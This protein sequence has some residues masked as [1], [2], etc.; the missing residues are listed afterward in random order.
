MKKRGCLLFFLFVPVLLYAQTAVIQ[1]TVRDTEGVGI[2][3][4]SINVY[5]ADSNLFGFGSTDSNG[6]Y[7]V[8]YLYPAS[9]YLK[10]YSTQNYL[11][12]WY[13]GVRVG[14]CDNQGRPSGATTVGVWYDGQI[15]SSIDF[16]L[17]PGAVIKG[18]VTNNAGT[19]IQDVW[20][21][22]YYSEYCTWSMKTDSSGFYE[23][24]GL[25]TGTYHVWADAETEYTPYLSEWY[26]DYL[27]SDSYPIPAEAT[28]I[29]VA[30]GLTNVIDIGLAA[31]GSISGRV[32][33][34][35]TGQG[36][37]RYFIKVYDT[38]LVEAGYALADENGGYLIPGL[39]SGL[40]V[41]ATCSQGTNYVNERYDDIPVRASWWEIDGESLVQVQKGVCTSGIDF[42]L[43]TGAAIEGLIVD[44]DGYP[45]YDAGILYFYRGYG[46]V[47]SVVSDGN[48]CFELLGLWT[49][50]YFLQFSPDM[51]ANYIPEWY[52]DLQSSS[53]WSIP[54]GA[55]GISVVENGPTS[56]V[57]VVMK[58]GGQIW[59]RVTNEGGQGLVSIQ[60]TAYDVASSLSESAAYANTDEN[61]YYTLKGLDS[62]RY[63]VKCCM[64]SW[65]DER[66]YVA[67][68]YD[69]IPY[70]LNP[71]RT[72]TVVV[73]AKG[74][75]V[76]N[77]DF[78]LSLEGSISGRVTSVGGQ[79]ISNLTVI[80]ENSAGDEAGRAETD[81]NGEY[82]VA[83]LS[84]GNYYVHTKEDLDSYIDEYY[85]NSAI[86][87]STISAGADL[88]AVRSGAVT[89]GVHFVLATGGEIR[90]RV[91]GA[92]QP[93]SEMW[94]A[95][96]NSRNEVM[97]RDDRLTTNGEYSIPG[98]P[99]GNYYVK[100][101]I[102]DGWAA[103]WYDN[104][105]V[106][107]TSPSAG[108]SVVVVTQGV[109]TQGV[110]FDLSVGGVITGR[111][112]DASGRP[113]SSV[114]VE[115]YNANFDWFDC[116][117]NTDTGGWYALTG[118]SSG[119][120]YIVTWCS[121]YP[122]V[123][124]W[125]S[126][127]SVNGDVD[128]ATMIPIKPG[129]VTGS[130][131]FVLSPE[132]FNLSSG[133]SNGVFGWDWDAN[134]GRLY[135]VQISHDLVHWSNAVPGTSSQ[136]AGRLSTNVTGS[137]IRYSYPFPMGNRPLFGRV[138]AVE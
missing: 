84:A 135:Q 50:T 124:E 68:W 27:S 138:K 100:T 19:P 36:L 80:A 125:Y 98:L 46:N 15:V 122:Y 79:P 82:M 73:V 24:Y 101:E 131:D 126:N 87:S 8:S 103:E 66:P 132:T 11:N 92:G 33:S 119:L 76:S 1:G 38:N 86:T 64:Y 18:M 9:Y 83:G 62:G 67:E 107:G 93:L 29:S 108:A 21:H 40:Y 90:G 129:S 120:Y 41:V 91:T 78:T 49:D 136:Q 105:A 97:A 88:V 35:S 127:I 31:G 74:G 6:A 3:D 61:G 42:V 55:A 113:L 30:E 5:D 81:T 56:F 10:T 60:V 45:V 26:N 104:I 20:L 17:S 71:F 110:N 44:E 115:V 121:G 59:G 77:I 58:E 75:V 13:G 57:Q 99:T 54:A 133:I 37:S 111:V 106:T 16:E 25:T 85:D 14:T 109:V 118:L 134:V 12:E 102:A 51:Y 116:G 48:G 28:P 123:D 128:L 63:N 23:F 137:R 22:L 69:N 70:S 47:N 52:D 114:Y 53:S 43:A 39:S 2:A 112:T 117:D 94:V 96:H 4:V 72:G 95:A 65:L 130:I 89:G 7:T 34:L 32:T